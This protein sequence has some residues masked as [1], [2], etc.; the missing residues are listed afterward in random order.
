MGNRQPNIFSGGACREG[1]RVAK[2]RYFG[3]SSELASDTRRNRAS[4][5]EAERHEGD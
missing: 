4:R 5:Q 2:S 3:R 1:A